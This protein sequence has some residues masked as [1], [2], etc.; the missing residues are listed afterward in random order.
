V[1]AELYGSGG[2]AELRLSWTPPGQ[3]EQIVP[4]GRFFLT[5]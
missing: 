3:P 2:A 5:P 1:R 4:E